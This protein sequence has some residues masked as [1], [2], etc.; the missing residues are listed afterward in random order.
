MDQQFLERERPKGGFNQ[1]SACLEALQG[2]F[3]G[4]RRSYD[5]EAVLCLVQYPAHFPGWHYHGVYPG[6]AA[7][8]QQS[9]HLVRC[10]S[11]GD[12]EGDGSVVLVAQTQVHYIVQ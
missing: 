11:V 2:I 4:I 12:S 5:R 10:L 7:V 6:Q 8:V 3:Y 9:A 1:G